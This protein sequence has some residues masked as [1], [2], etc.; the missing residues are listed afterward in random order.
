MNL[1]MLSASMLEHQKNSIRNM[2]SKY[3]IYFF[4]LNTY[5]KDNNSCSII[6]APNKATFDNNVIGASLSNNNATNEHLKYSIN[7][8]TSRTAARN[9]SSCAFSIAPTRNE[10]LVNQNYDHEHSVELESSMNQFNNDTSNIML[11]MKLFQ[12]VS[13]H[14][15]EEKIKHG[16]LI[17]SMIM[18]LHSIKEKYNFIMSILWT[19]IECKAKVK[20]T[21]N[22]LLM[23]MT[24]GNLL[25]IFLKHTMKAQITLMF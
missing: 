18:R 9:I 11:I 13:E 7:L 12:I 24:I 8:R 15:L 19:F 3:A 6:A 23:I 25:Q 1:S 2:M 20:W 16:C 14:K 4:E 10:H 22:L 17:A 21:M 5:R